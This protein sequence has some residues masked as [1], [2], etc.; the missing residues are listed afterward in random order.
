MQLG[1]RYLGGLQWCGG[2]ESNFRPRA[3]GGC[4]DSL[5]DSSPWPRRKS[6]LPA[7]PGKRAYPLGGSKPSA[8]HCDRHESLEIRG[9]SR[10]AIVHGFANI[11]ELRSS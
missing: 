3:R 2:I 9:M 5:F 10:D 7:G 1:L 6:G 11:H 4:T 8:E